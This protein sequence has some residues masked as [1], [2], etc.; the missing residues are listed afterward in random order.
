MLKD[1]WGRRVEPLGRADYCTATI[2]RDRVE[3]EPDAHGHF[4][5]SYRFADIRPAEQ[6][7]VTATAYRQRE[8]RDF[9][10]VRGE[11][12]HSDSPFEQPDR[13]VAADSLV[14]IGYERPIRLTLPAPAAEWEPATGVLRIRRDDG[15]VT[16]VFVERGDRPGFRLSGPDADGGHQVD[17][18]PKGSELNATATTPVDFVIYDTAERKYEAGLILDTP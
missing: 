4:R 15:T 8:G 3:A 18:V 5:F 11:W 6:I 10:K 17:Y 9:M 7:K 13:K 2:G 14:L 12:L 1:V 16:S